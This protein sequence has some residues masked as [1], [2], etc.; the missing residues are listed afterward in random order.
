M[1][2][3]TRYLPT[4]RHARSMACLAGCCWAF[5]AASAA[6]DRMCIGSNGSVALPL[7]AQDVCFCGSVLGCGGGTLFQG[8]SFIQS[9]EPQHATTRT[10]RHTRQRPRPP[11]AAAPAAAGG[12]CEFTARA[13]PVRGSGRRDGRTAN[14]RPRERRPLRGGWLLLALLAASLPP[15]RAFQDGPVPRG[16][17]VGLPAG[18]EAALVPDRVRRGRGG[19]ARVVRGGQ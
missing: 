16:G 10:Q 13:A 2:S 3:H 4:L 11:T 17:L 18:V 14:G 15:P 12:C 19:A 9:S 6:S 7:S 5:G 8:W 1:P